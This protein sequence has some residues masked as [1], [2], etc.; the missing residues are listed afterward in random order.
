[1][2]S[3]ENEGTPMIFYWKTIMGQEQKVTQLFLPAENEN[4]E[5]AI[6]QNI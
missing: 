3:K 2:T 6:M 4:P 1:M 5:D